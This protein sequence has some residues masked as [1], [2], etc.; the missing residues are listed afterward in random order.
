MPYIVHSLVILVAL[1]HS[2]TVEQCSF[3]SPSWILLLEIADKKKFNLR[4]N[5]KKNILVSW[6]LMTNKEFSFADIKHTQ[7]KDKKSYQKCHFFFFSI[8]S[9]EKK[10]KAHITG[11]S[12]PFILQVFILTVFWVVLCHWR[13]PLHHNWTPFIYIA[14]SAVCKHYTTR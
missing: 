11:L 7:K 5:L 9:Q 2:P 6:L 4:K 3:I 12:M 8:I 1:S 14:V 13:P 10:K